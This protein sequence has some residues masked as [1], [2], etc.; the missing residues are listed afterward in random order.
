M[1]QLINKNVIKWMFSYWP[2]YSFS[3]SHIGL[4][5]AVLALSFASG[6]YSHHQANMTDLRPVTGPISKQPF[7]KIII[8]RQNKEQIK[9]RKV[10]FLA[11]NLYQTSRQLKID[12]SD[13]MNILSK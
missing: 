4:R 9:F 3:A 13:K 2:C 11:D 8:L 6:Q 7:N 1:K 5:M 10:I 12:T